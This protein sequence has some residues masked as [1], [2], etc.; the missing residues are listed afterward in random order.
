MANNE[1]MVKNVGSSASIILDA[2]MDR[3]RCDLSALSDDEVRAEAGE[4]CF[5]IVQNLLQLLSI[6]EDNFNRAFDVNSREGDEYYKVNSISIFDLLN[7]IEKYESL[8]RL[9]GITEE[10]AKDLVNQ[11]LNPY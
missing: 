5:E 10:K 3:Y 1:G 9:Y 2:A 7:D 8:S 6:L 11:K 4:W